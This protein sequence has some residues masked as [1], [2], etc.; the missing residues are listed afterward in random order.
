MSMKGF[1]G[2]VKAVI[3][4]PSGETKNEIGEVI[5]DYTEVGKTD[6][7]INSRVSQYVRTETGFMRQNTWDAF[8]PFETDVAQGDIITLSGTSYNVSGVDNDGTGQFL[9][10][11]LE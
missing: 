10:L 8:V 5:L 4:R 7:R 11:S 9:K 2:K 6:I 3:Q 1:Y